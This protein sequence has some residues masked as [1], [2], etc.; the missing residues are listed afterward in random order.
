MAVEEE[1]EI[2]GAMAVEQER[3]MDS[4][5]EIRGNVGIEGGMWAQRDGEV[6]R[7][8]GELRERESVPMV[9]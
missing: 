7:G 5:I 6:G 1:G 4:G 9:A 2:S 3:E 8:R